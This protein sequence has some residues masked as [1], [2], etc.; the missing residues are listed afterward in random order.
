MPARFRL[1]FV[2]IDHPHGAGWREALRQLEPEVEIVALVPCFG[3][4][5]ASLEEHYSAAQR[6]ETVAELLR[7]G[8]FDGAMVCLP[9][10]ESP[11]ACAALAS[12]G[13]HIAAE[14]PGAAAARDFE[15]VVNA[16]KQSGVA[17]QAGYLW[18]Y[19]AGA[20]R[21]REMVADGRFGKL[22]SVEMTMVTSD[23]IR[24]G[25]AHYLFDPNASGRGY[26]SWLGC[27]W[28]DLLP[29]ITGER[30]VAVTA[31]TGV[32]GNVAMSVEDGGTAILELSGGGLA[33]LIGGY[34][35]PRWITESH[36]T[37]RGCQ[38][39]LKW[40]PT[41]AGTGGTFQIH[42]PQPQF[43]AME[44]TFSL[45]VDS[46]PGYGGARS[47]HLFHDWLAETRGEGKKCRNDVEASMDVLKLLDAVYQSSA[48]G[49]RIVV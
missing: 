16:V 46:T 19:D 37:M 14:K 24:R 43:H 35:L 32:F 41:R 4:A 7:W 47:L 28:L 38:R 29:Y 12:A 36:W 5:T 31:R 11:A 6:F 49:R 2:G 8:E 25:P 15:P 1:A 23:V 40:E 3:Q 30:I 10:S 26:F 42:G 34:W 13:K 22:I 21:L 45:P 27:H 39:W 17:F 18:R 33:T 44:E 48:E 9:N 20:N